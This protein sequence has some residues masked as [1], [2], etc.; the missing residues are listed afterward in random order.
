MTSLPRAMLNGTPSNLAETTSP[1]EQQVKPL[2]T[3]STPCTSRSTCRHRTWGQIG[4]CTR[5]TEPIF[6]PVQRFPLLLTRQTVEG[7]P[8]APKTCS[9]PYVVC[10]TRARTAFRST[11]LRIECCFVIHVIWS[12]TKAAI[13]A[14]ALEAKLGMFLDGKFLLQTGPSPTLTVRTGF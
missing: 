11:D 3:E 7:T 13:A 6:V 12:F 14:A 9:N 4:E 8:Y 5:T 10:Q 2:Q 1:L